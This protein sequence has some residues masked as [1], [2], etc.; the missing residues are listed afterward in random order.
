MTT[1]YSEIVKA[2]EYEEMRMH[3]NNDLH[4]QAEPPAEKAE[5]IAK[6]ADDYDFSEYPGEYP[7][8]F[9]TVTMGS[10]GRDNAL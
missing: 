5:E 8:D 2:A 9:E 10:E 7:G 3:F 6:E 1:T 4:G